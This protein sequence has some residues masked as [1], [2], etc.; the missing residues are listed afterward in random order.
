M[1]IFSNKLIIIA[2]NHNDENP[3]KVGNYD[4]D[5]VQ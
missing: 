4:D 3:R 2:I 1:A 5:D